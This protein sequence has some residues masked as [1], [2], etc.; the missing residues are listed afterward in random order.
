[1]ITDPET[2]ARLWVGLIAAAPVM[3]IGLA[4]V[5][6]AFVVRWK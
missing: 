4:L 1:M 3:L 6:V 2:Y 5:V